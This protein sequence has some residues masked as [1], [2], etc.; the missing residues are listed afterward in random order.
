MVL[1]IKF[2]SRLLKSKVD[3][4][5]DTGYLYIGNLSNV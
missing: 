3:Y 5:N 2:G 1:N 4:I